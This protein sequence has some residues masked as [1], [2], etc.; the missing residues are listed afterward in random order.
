[1]SLLYF[2]AASFAEIIG[3]YSFWAWLRLNK[4]CIYIIPGVAFLIMFAYLL[5]LV[6]SEF[7]G[8]AYAAYGAV[9]IVSSL[10]WMWGF[11]KVVPSKWD[12]VGA[13]FSIFGA[14]II[15]FGMIKKI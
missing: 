5:T 3:C 8:R 1:M 14:M 11:E 12:I 2:I 9:Y 4:S 15:I 13:T 7:A 6:E 10:L